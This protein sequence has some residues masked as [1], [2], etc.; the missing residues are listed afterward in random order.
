MRGLL[1]IVRAPTNSANVLI[2]SIAAAAT[3]GALIGIGRR[4][5]SAGLPFA[6]TAAVLFHRTPSAAA[7]G[8][9]FLGLVLHVVFSFAWAAAFVWLADGPVRRDAVAA[10]TVALAQFAIGGL[11]HR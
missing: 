7:I 9:V 5:G 6:A 2:G 11:S 10:G 1:W 4:A 8:L 3:T